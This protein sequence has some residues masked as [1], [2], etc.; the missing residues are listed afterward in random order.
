MYTNN[1]EAVK[2]DI[3]FAPQ[4]NIAAHTT[5]INVAYDEYLTILNRNGFVFE[6]SIPTK[7]IFMDAP[8][9]RL[10]NS[11]KHLFDAVRYRIGF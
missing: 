11:S 6:Q 8:V 3:R 2:H 7:G 10:G 9:T 5:F 1:L 4:F